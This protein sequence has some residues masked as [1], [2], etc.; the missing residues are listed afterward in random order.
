MPQTATKKQRPAAAPAVKE[1][2]LFINN[3]WVNPADGK[4]FDTYNPAT[5]QVLAKVA[6]ASAADVDKAVK[7]ARKALESGPWG[8][9]DAADRGRLLFKLADLIEANKKELAALETLNCGKTITD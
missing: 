9:M 1:T 3:Q 4:T 7:A 8:K 6:H 5:G 2:R